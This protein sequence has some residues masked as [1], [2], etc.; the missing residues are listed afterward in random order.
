MDGATFN[1]D[2]TVANFF[3]L[4]YAT[5]YATASSMV[6]IIH[7]FSESFLRPPAHDRSPTA[8][9]RSDDFQSRGNHSPA[10]LGK[11]PPLTVP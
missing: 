8:T 7:D 2:P 3:Y 6:L 10:P 9:A 4:K 11:M 1:G 5:S